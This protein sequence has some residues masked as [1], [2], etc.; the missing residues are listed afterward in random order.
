MS[1]VA[2]SSNPEK[3]RTKFTDKN[4]RL[5]VDPA[6]L[7]T[8]NYVRLQTAL[9]QQQMWTVL[10]RKSGLEAIKKEQEELHKKNSDRYLDK[11][12][13]AHW[14]KLYGVG[15]VVVGHTQCFF[16]SKL[17]SLNIKDYYCDQMINLVDANSGEVILGVEG[18]QFTDGPEI[19]PD[20]KEMAMKL[21]DA[22]PKR[23]ERVPVSEKLETYKAESE[24]EAKRV[25]GD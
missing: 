16:K 15:A 20:W 23:F 21:A 6:S 24:E 5:M 25:T 11:E 18:G 1:L 12:K 2:C 17:F 22:Y 7:S 19:A 10:D 9:V 8:E 4:M 14:G 3:Y 13:F